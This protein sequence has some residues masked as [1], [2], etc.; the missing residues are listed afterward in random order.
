MKLPAKI[1]GLLFIFIFLEG[2]W[3]VG[4]HRCHPFCNSHEHEQA[5]CNLVLNMMRYSGLIADSRNI[6]IQAANRMGRKQL[7]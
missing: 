3:C 7:G 4:G 6:R 1:G 5:C 2:F